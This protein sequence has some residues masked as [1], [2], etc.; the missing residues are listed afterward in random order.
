MRIQ[1]SPLV[2]TNSLTG[3][4]RSTEVSL[5]TEDSNLMLILRFKSKNSDPS[6]L[7]KS[8]PQLT[9][10]IQRPSLMSR[11]R[12]SVDHAGH[13]PQLELLRVLMLRNT[14][15]SS[16]SQSNSSLIATSLRTL[17]AVVAL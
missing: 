17:P 14:E 8:Q 16:L 7:F 10:E 12:D 11:I 9:G 13:S 3:L 6:K 15:T 2:R 1:P 5:D 4:K